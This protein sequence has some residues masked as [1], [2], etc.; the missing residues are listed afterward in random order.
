MNILVVNDDGIKA[1]GIVR[2]AALAKTLG[3]VTVVAPAHQCSGMSHHISFEKDLI[4]KKVPFPVED[5]DAYSITGTPADCVRVGI[6]SIIEEKPDVV[7]S[8]INK[9]YNIGYE[10]MYSGTVG[11]AMEA[12]VYGVPAIAFS[13]FKFDDFSAMETYFP[14]IMKELEKR[15]IG[16]NQ[17]WNINVPHCTA[18]E[19]QGITYDCKPARLRFYHDH[20]D[21]EQLGNTMYLVREIYTRKDEAPEGS[22]CAVLLENKIA[23]GKLTSIV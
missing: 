20:F 8:G 2:L 1:E 18:Q 12:L 14:E 6:S 10:I 3:K 9:G 11:A 5:V 13:Q 22:D 15:E 7:F 19:I 21:K 17:I 16:D 23:I 4:L